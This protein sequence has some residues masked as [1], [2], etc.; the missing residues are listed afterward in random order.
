MAWATIEQTE[1]I[2]GITVTQPELD[3]AQ[4]IIDIVT[5]RSEDVGTYLTD[6]NKTRDLYYL[7]LAAA[8]QAAW[9]KGQPD[10]FTRKDVTQLNQ[11]GLSVT[12]GPSGNT[13]APLARRSVR[14]LSWMGTR[15]VSVQ[16]ARRDSIAQVQPAGAPIRDYESDVWAPMS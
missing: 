11:D 4:A 6:D 10:L 2:T 15:S 14:R 9:M 1:D 13:L 8:Y 5:G 3:R 7:K 12:L 16:K